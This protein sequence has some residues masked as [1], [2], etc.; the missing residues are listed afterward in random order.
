MNDTKLG[1][2]ILVEL[3]MIEGIADPKNGDLTIEMVAQ[4]LA[5]FFTHKI[6]QC[7]IGAVEECKSKIREVRDYYTCG[8][9]KASTLSVPL[10]MA[11]AKIDD[12]LKSLGEKNE[13]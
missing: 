2:Q 11:I 4:N 13:R 6:H 3:K 8:G 7:Q 9:T 12:Y 1:E 5:N 10:G